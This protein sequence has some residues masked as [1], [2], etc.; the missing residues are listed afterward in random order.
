M[1]KQWKTI[2]SGEKTEGF[3]NYFNN[4]EALLKEKAKITNAKDIMDVNFLD[5]ALSIRSLKKVKDTMIKL[6]QSNAT[7]NEK[8][9]DLFATEIVS[10]TSTHIM[11]VTF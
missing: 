1:F 5:K 7:N 8:N 3:F 6:D 2:K 11:Y 9:N 4:M 10:M